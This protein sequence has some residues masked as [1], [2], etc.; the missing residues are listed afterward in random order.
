MSKNLDKGLDGP[1]RKQEPSIGRI[2]VYNH[3]GS[4]DGKFLKKQSPAIIQKVNIP[5]GPNQETVELFV[6]SVYGG[7][8]FNHDVVQGDGP[9]QWNWPEII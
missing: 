7:I 4:A 1:A 5:F 3:P 2:V 6:M 8:F 9:G